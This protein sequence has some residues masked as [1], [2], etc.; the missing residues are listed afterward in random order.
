MIW[1]VKYKNLPPKLDMKCSLY[2]ENF[3]KIESTNKHSEVPT[4]VISIIRPI[5]Y[6]QTSLIII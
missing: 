6:I 2:A 1:L 5:P 4:Y 3:V